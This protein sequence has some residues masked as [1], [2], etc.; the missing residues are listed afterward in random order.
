MDAEVVA[1]PQP[2]SKDS[3]GSIMDMASCITIAIVVVTSSS[4]P[5]D[6]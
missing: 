6:F 1:P 3:D 5:S 4:V 2:D